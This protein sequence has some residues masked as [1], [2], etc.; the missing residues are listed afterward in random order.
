MSDP[1]SSSPSEPEFER[2]LAV[3]QGYF[4]L[5]MWQESWDELEELG[6]EFRHLAPVI[7][8]RVLILNNLG[9]W[10][11]AAIVGPG[12]LR[13]FPG[14]GALYLATAQALRE[15]QGA[16]A[17]KAVIMAGG[18]LLRNEAA[19]HYNLACYDSALG[20]LDDAKEGLTRTFELEKGL[21]QK[22]LD[23]PDLAPVWESLGES[24]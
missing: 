10:E 8:L 20:K 15:C 13:Y 5:E 23:E 6:P 14:F 1:D 17:A 4:A 18:R 19:F 16:A 3:A 22:A 9:K 24:E 2:T 21:R 7:I 11:S 12:A